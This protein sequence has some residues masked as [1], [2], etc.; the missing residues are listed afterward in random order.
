MR[1]SDLSTRLR[2]T[3]SLGERD[4]ERAAFPLSLGGPGCAVVVDTA[5]SGPL[6]WLGLDEDALFVQPVSAGTLLHNG[7][8][9]QA[10][11]WLHV[12]DVITVGSALLRVANRDGTR[13]LIV[14]D[15][16]AGN[17]TAPPVIERAELLS[18]TTTAGIEPVVSLKYRSAQGGAPKAVASKRGPALIGGAGLLV[19]LVLWFLGSGVAVQLKVQPTD[20]K[21]AVTGS[22]LT[23]RFGMQLFVRPGHYTL[24]ALA[25][26]YQAQS[27]AFLVSDRPGQSVTLQLGKLPGKVRVELAAPGTLRVDGGVAMPVPGVLEVRAGKHA[28]RIE[29]AGYLPYQGAI[30]VEGEGK[31]QKFAPNLIADSASI[32]ISSEPSAAQVLIDNQPAGVTPLNLKLAASTHHLE[33]RLGGFKPWSMDLLVKV[34]EPQTIGPVRLGLPDASLMVRSNPSGARVMAGGVYRGETPLKLS[35]PPEVTTALS[36]ALPGHEDAAR[37]VRLHPAAHE[38]MNVELT[39]I[40]G[41]ITLHVMPADAEV[42]VD[43]AM[44]GHGSQALSLTTVAHQVEVRKSGLVTASSTV[45]PRPGL[46]QAVDVTLLTEAQ[47]RAAR[48]PV[49]VRAHGAIDM[50]LMPVGHYIMGSTRREPDRRANEGQRPVELRRQYYLAT[51]EISNAQFR[52]FRPEHKS[53]MFGGVSLNVDNQPV[54]Q[55]TWQDAA[56]YCNWLSQQDG[57][58]PAYHQE[59]GELVAVSPMTTGYRLP[60]EAEWEW[61]ARAG[62]TQHRYPWGDA[63][64]VAA[65]SGNYADATAKA[66]LTDVIAGYDDGFLAAAPV[67][68]FAASPLGLYDLGGNVSEWTTD[69]Y[70]TSYSAEAI[71]V[72]PMNLAAG[73]QH[74]VRGASWRTAASGELRVAARAAG[75]APRDDL[76]FRIA[77]YVE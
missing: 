10:S 16:G 32:A 66:M 72:D 62:P 18:G 15:G 63:L 60:S 70:A 42:W 50:R 1:G 58:P 56:A 75:A 8:P 22:W 61:A 47:Q 4:V 20:A 24:H 35:L 53:G 77:R 51:H 29:S 27:F 69:L 54:V 2:I 37:T 44:R 71:A 76:G 74:A 21:L 6:A 13:Q 19:L 17:A 3:D 55:V 7:T 65:N 28:V 68:S 25:P 46:E 34:G 26:G 57:L 43:G 14:D 36:L 52:E 30:V 5:A 41:K 12:G 49:S 45:T 67:G 38:E 23:P 40:L 39:P 73:N 31:A 64:P 59:N 9:V 11:T 33:L 48:I